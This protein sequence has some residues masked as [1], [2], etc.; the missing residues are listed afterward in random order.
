MRDEK[1][2]LKDAETPKDDLVRMMTAESTAQPQQAEGK[3]AADAKPA[4]TG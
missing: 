4:S 1:R 3:T 2:A